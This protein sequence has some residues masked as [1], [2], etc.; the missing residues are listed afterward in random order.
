MRSETPPLVLAVVERPS[1]SDDAQQ[2]TPECVGERPS[3]TRG[4]RA[5]DVMLR[6]S[7]DVLLDIDRRSTTK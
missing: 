4:Q 7:R 5:L 3:K 2:A 1:D 6:K